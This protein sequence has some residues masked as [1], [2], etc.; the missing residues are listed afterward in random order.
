MTKI[1]IT[2]SSGFIGGHVCLSMLKNIE[3]IQIIAVDKIMFDNNEYFLKH[4]YNRFHENI[5]DRFKFYK[6]DLSESNFED[7]IDYSSID[8]IIHLA[9]PVGVNNIL[10]NQN[11]TEEA[12]KINLNIKKVAKKYNIPVIFT[13]SSEIYGENI[14]IDE[15][16]CSSISVAG[17]SKR[18]GYAAQKLVSEYLFNDI[19]GITYRLFNITGAGHKNMVL[20][21][22][23]QSVKDNSIF[24][25]TNSHRI[26]T[27][28]K[29]LCDNIMME[30]NNFLKHDTI[31]STRVYINFGFPYI[32]IDELSQEYVRLTN[33][34]YL[35]N[36]LLIKYNIDKKVKD[37]YVYKVYDE[38]I[39]KRILLN[40]DKTLVYDIFKDLNYT[41]YL[42][43]ILEDILI[44]EFKLERIN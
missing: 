44:E 2:G 10:D 35:L 13:S 8:Y 7:L 19:P 30:V 37:E 12:L 27:N 11:S 16:S 14:N 3:D 18:G 17:K 20:S 42:E 21:K 4:L 38:E 23:V 36:E 26:F 29:D 32:N 5:W 31:A 15:N 24:K 9:S 41:E 28:V 25:I 34:P 22:M 40:N 1:L 6:L 33:I 39:M 43:N